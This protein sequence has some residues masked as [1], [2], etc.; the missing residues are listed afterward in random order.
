M[1]EFAENLF[2][3]NL[4]KDHSSVDCCPVCSSS[5]S[6]P[7][8]S[9]FGY[10][11]L[12]CVTCGFRYIFQ[13]PSEQFLKEYYEKQYCQDDGSFKP[14][15]GFFRWL[16]YATFTKYLKYLI[17]KNQVTGSDKVRIVELGCG[18]GDLLKAFRDDPKVE[19]VGMDY[20]AGPVNHLKSVGC[21]ANLGGLGEV[22]IADGK[23]MRLSCFTY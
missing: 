20:A 16:K 2:N 8:R 17:S 21:N 3:M 6:K 5:V 12:E 19:I 22:P 18:Q 7:W 4:L 23:L 13:L 11:I 9:K 1:Q 15:G 10:D 14:K